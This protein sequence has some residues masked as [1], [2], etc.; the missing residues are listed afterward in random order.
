M[1]RPRQPVIESPLMHRVL[2]LALAVVLLCAMIPLPLPIRVVK[3]ASE[4]FPCQ[5]HTCGCRTAAQ[6]WKSCCCFTNTQKVEWAER[7][8][9]KVPDFVIVAAT[10][11]RSRS[12]TPSTCCSKHRRDEV[13]CSTSVAQAES[14]VLQRNGDNLRVDLSTIATSREQECVSGICTNEPATDTR[15][16]IGWNALKCSGVS[17]D[18][19]LG[20]VLPPLPLPD[21]IVFDVSSQRFESVSRTLLSLTLLP[22][23]PPPRVL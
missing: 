9:A 12:G 10:Q 3:D 11:E 5:H 13:R 14:P 16:V 22:P 15:L 21:V 7:E 4:A 20:Y 17:W 6:C 23:E 18:F 8:R 2:C 1:N 19:A